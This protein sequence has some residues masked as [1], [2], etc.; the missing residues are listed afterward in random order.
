MNYIVKMNLANCSELVDE[1]VNLEC[2]V[3]L[4]ISDPEERRRVLSERS[5]YSSMSERLY[6]LLD[7]MDET[8]NSELA[9]LLKPGRKRRVY[10]LCYPSM[11][12]DLL[13]MLKMKNVKSV[14]I[15]DYVN[16]R[17]R[18]ATCD[19]AYVMD[20]YLEGPGVSG[21]CPSLVRMSTSMAKYMREI[22]DV[23]RLMEM[24]MGCT[25]D[26]SCVVGDEMS[27]SM[28]VLDM[29]ELSLRWRANSV[30]EKCLKR[31]CAIL[32]MMSYGD[33]VSMSIRRE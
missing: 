18:V 20:R 32:H 4:M 24:L 17:S 8:G 13:E 14:N 33:S 5:F 3:E 6:E 21:D 11:Y 26:I 23:G 10:A 15:I 9:D 7:A 1:T 30:S 25:V 12:V 31:Y 29:S 28:R 22:E 27:K 16:I 19:H 2:L